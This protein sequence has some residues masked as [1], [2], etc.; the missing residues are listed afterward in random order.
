MK[1]KK[2]RKTKLKN[3]VKRKRRNLTKRN[4]LISGKNS[5]KILNSVL[6]KTLEI[7]LSLPN[8]PDGT[9]AEIPLNSLPSMNI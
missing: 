9:Q 6:L 2:K 8:S 7:D 1:K 4:T 5:E 3:Q